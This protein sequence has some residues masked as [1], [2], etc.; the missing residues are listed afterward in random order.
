MQ[1]QIRVRGRNLLRPQGF[2]RTLH[3]V[4]SAGAPLM[5]LAIRLTAL[6]FIAASASA[7][8]AWNAHGHR[9]VTRLAL[10]GLSA[11]LP[12]W[13]KE[14]EVASRIMEQAN[15]PDRWRSTRRPAI[16]HEANQ[17]HYIDVE[18]LA[19]MG[20]SLRTLPVYRYEAVRLM[21]KARLEHPESF[22]PI[23]PAKDVD[24]TKEWP[25][26]LPWAIA[27]H[28]TKLQSSF[29]TLRI[30]EEVNDADRAPQL[31]QARENVIY[32]VGILSHFVSDASQPLHT[33]R[34][35][36]GWV[37]PNPQGYTTDNGFHAYID[38]KILEIHRL[39]Y[40]A[41]RPRVKFEATVN[42][43]D[44]WKDCAGYI[45]RSFDQVEPLYRLQKDG[46][47]VRDAGREFISDRLCEGASMLAAMVN[48]AWRESKP[49][50]GDI[51]S[52]L[53]FSEA[54]SRT[55]PPAATPPDAAPP[56]PR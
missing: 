24:H 17:E 37:G 42:S 30:L 44:P 45:E 22:A 55:R 26:F 7:A 38:G 41:L 4:P 1:A 20:L 50:A 23:D 14:P 31:R 56:G 8:F 40:A 34:H 2:A 5:T 53:K 29:H 52:F 54:R 25:G 18:D 9:T 12:P 51:S 36:H 16:L 28:Y 15:E 32:E 6:V 27:E 21:V 33:T 3:S 10:D 46:A 13:L 49:S 19:P 39:D 47:L 11:D 48:A 35:H 43:K